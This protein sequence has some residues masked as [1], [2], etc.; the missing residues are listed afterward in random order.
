MKFLNENEFYYLD[1]IKEHRN[2]SVWWQHLTFVD[3]DY[4]YYEFKHSNAFSLFPI[5]ELIPA[6]DFQRLKNGEIKLVIN[7][8]HESFHIIVEGLYQELILKAGIP[9]EQIVLMSESADILFEIRKYSNLYN[10]KEIKCVWT[11]IMEFDIKCNK[12]LMMAVDGYTEPNTLQHKVYN[13]KFINFN[14]RWRLHRPVLVGLLY[15][16]NLLSEGYVSMASSDDNRSWETVWANMLSC[17]ANTPEIVE[18]FKNNEHAIL[19]MPNLYIDTND[20]VTNRAILESSTDYL[21]ENTYFSVVSETNYY[22][23][24]R[25]EDGLPYYSYHGF[26]RHLTEKVFKTIAN[27]HPALLVSPPHSLIKL[28]ELGYKTF[29]PW[30]DESYDLELNDSKRMLKVIAEIKRLCEL[31]PDMLSDFLTN[32]KPICDYNQQILLNQTTFLT[33]LN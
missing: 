27:K 20:L 3:Q 6:N 18:L 19:N 7:N 33:Q 5:T 10:V 28:R 30:I 2:G 24:D 22:T 26:G 15:A 32:V 1:T 17:H 29:S 14:R 9:S 16:T 12:Q 31:S 21:Y 8:S 23:S 4:Y 25:F 11:R 13:K